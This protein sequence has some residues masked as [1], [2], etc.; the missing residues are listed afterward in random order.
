VFREG[1]HVVGEKET[2]GN[3]DPEMLV[4]SDECSELI[5]GWD[6][7]GRNCAAVIAEKQMVK[8]GLL[9]PELF[10]NG[11]AKI[12]DAVPGMPG[13]HAAA[14]M[15]ADKEFPVFKFIDELILVAEDFRMEDFVEQFVAKMDFWEKLM[16][17]TG[18]VAWRH[19]SD[20]SAFEATLM[21]A[22]RYIYELIYEISDGRISLMS[23]RGNRGA[24]SAR[25]DLW[26][27]LLWEQ[28]VWFSAAKCPQL[29]QMNK[30][31]KKG[32]TIGAVIQKGSPFKH[33]FDAPSYLQASEAF[34]ELAKS[35]R[36]NIRRKRGENTLVS[37]G[38]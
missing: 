5:T 19:W 30:S 26:R 36:V 15:S 37:V 7:G 18:R 17:K 33:A 2:P 10:Q 31:I 38:Y 28:R 1:V 35:I 13:K 22:D 23:E 4:P 8:A 12:I 20:R 29:I 11:D 27:K 3:K 9:W 34:D 14:S 6:P 16:G 24:V 32:T 21:F 25:V